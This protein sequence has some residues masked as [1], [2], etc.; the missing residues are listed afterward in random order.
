MQE[1]P[2]IIEHY[3]T[4][5]VDNGEKIV[6]N[7]TAAASPYLQIQWY[8]DGVRLCGGEH[9]AIETYKKKLSYLSKIVIQYTTLKDKV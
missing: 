3:L 9:I 5:T 2:R 8:K 7:C 6:L 1:P 4:Q